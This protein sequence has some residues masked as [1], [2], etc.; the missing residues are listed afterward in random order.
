MKEAPFLAFYKNH[1]LCRTFIVWWLFI[2]PEIRKK[3]KKNGSLLTPLIL[4]FKSLFDI[5]F[6]VCFVGNTAAVETLGKDTE[7]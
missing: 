3:K 4:L 2:L 7:I 6:C 5:C 1:V